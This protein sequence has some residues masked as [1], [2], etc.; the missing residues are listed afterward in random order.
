MKNEIENNYV[1]I[2][3]ILIE[4]SRNNNEIE[5]AHSLEKDLWASVLM[6]IG[7][8]C[9]D[10]HYKNLARKTMTSNKANLARHKGIFQ[11]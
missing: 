3:L 9:S 11:I 6:S 7:V 2:M 1:D 4:Q 10:E 5:K 8:Y